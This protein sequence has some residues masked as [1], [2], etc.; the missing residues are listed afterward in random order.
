MSKQIL[1]TREDV[2]AYIY[3]KKT[4]ASAIMRPVETPN[5]PLCV[6]SF[7]EGNYEY[8]EETLNKTWDEKLPLE[9]W[10]E[11]EEYPT[12]S[13]ICMCEGRHK[14]KEAKEYCQAEVDA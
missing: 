8:F 5:R 12:Q 4:P 3:R 10:D 7:R 9:A 13:H 2:V 11:C 1:E 14:I 6:H